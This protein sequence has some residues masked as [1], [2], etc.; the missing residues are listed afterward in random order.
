MLFICGNFL[1]QALLTPVQAADYLAGLPLPQPA[2]SGGGNA[3]YYLEL[4]ING[5]DSGQ[6]VPVNAADGH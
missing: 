4:V 5:R 6:V 1:G 2:P 3:L